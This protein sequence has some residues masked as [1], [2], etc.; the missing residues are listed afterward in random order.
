MMRLCLVSLIIALC[1][2]APASNQGQGQSGT[3]SGENK[4]S[5]LSY[6]CL[7]HDLAVAYRT[8]CRF[9]REVYKVEDNVNLYNTLYRP[10]QIDLDPQVKF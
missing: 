4:R 5:V 10:K 8:A 7:V 6:N 9:N 2:G 3:A 1:H